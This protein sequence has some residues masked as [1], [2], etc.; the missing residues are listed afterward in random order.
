MLN[1][2]IGEFNKNIG[3]SFTP[4]LIKQI[5]VTYMR[6]NEMYGDY[7]NQDTIIIKKFKN[8]ADAVKAKEKLLANEIKAV[9]EGINWKAINST[10]ELSLR[11]FQKDKEKALEILEK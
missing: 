4:D 3:G 5:R 8:E 1:S 9:L 7:T 11:V 2:R 10:N 6:S